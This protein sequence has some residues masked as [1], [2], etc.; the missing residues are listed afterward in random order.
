[1]VTAWWNWT[2][3]FLSLSLALFLGVKKGSDHKFTLGMLNACRGKS[4][5]H[6]REVWLLEAPEQ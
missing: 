1:M 3:W 6:R 2:E 4:Q 5:E